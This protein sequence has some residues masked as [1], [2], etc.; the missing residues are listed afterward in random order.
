[1]SRLEIYKKQANGEF[2]VYRDIWNF[3]SAQR[4]NA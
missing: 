3:N 1:M 4:P 2:L